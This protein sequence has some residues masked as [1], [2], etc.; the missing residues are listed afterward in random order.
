[1]PGGENSILSMIISLRN[2]RALLKVRKRY[3]RSSLEGED[4]EE[5]YKYEHDRP[6]KFK[7]TKASKALLAKIRLEGVRDKRKFRL[8]TVAFIVLF[9]AISALIGFQFSQSKG[10]ISAPI[11][12]EQELENQLNRQRKYNYCMNDAV[13]WM[14]ERHYHNALFQYQLALEIVPGDKK[15]ELGIASVFIE[16]CNEEGIYCDRAYKWAQ[17]IQAKYPRDV[18]AE[19]LVNDYVEVVRNE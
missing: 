9:V 10:H 11:V 18:V 12:D 13:K 6:L 5:Q 7:K 19:S 14:A 17:K 16:Q 3:F 4:K 8:K 1:M 15:A 2:N